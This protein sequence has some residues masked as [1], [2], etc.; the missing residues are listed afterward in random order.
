MNA[1]AVEST[2]V[3]L[4]PDKFRQIVELTPLVSIDLVVRDDRGR[5]LLGVRENRPALGYWFVPGGRVGKNERIEVAF[6]RICEAELGRS[7]PFRSARFLGVFEHLYDD[8]FA[9]APGFGTHYIVL[10]YSFDC[11]AEGFDLPLD[12]HSAYDW[13]SDADVLSRS[14]VHPYCRA[15]CGR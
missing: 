8:N 11:V 14:D 2:P 3:R 4:S 1:N 7:P 12:Q 5:M 6:N 10:G 15:Y 13:L 9:G